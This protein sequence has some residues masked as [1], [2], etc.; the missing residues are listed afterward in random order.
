MGSTMG[1][2]MTHFALTIWLWEQTHQVLPIALLAFWT[3]VP[4]LIAA[5]FSGAI[6]DRWPR[7]YL[8]LLGDT[9]AGVSTVTILLLYLT[10][11]LQ[12]WHFYAA[13]I[14]TGIFAQLQTLAYT[15]SI[16][17]LLPETF[18]NRASGMASVLHYG[19]II[20]APAI[21][22]I[23]YPLIRF[24][25]ILAIDLGTFLF[26]FSTV[27]FIRIPPLQAKKKSE[28]TKVKKT[29]NQDIREGM[30]Y[31]LMRP[32]LLFLLFISALFQFVHDIG[33]SVYSPLILARSQ[34]NP[35]VLGLASAAAGL[36][37]ILGSIGVSIKPLPG[38]KT[39]ALF[40]GMV[41]AG[42]CKTVFGLGQNL[43]VWFPAQF[44]S[45]VNFPVMASAKQAILW[46]DVKPELQGRVFA[47]ASLLT[48]IA[49]P[50]AK[51]LAGWLAD[52]FFEPAMRENGALSGSLGGLFG[53]NSGAGMAVLYTLSSLGLIAVGSIAF[54]TRRE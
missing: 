20:I 51:P 37:G 36:G 30:A 5:P 46:T 38:R 24:S 50:L 27:A 23:L 53:T 10:E 1:S 42:L 54:L 39:H 40:G 43:W 3:E 44:A 41:G 47:V 52:R 4:R 26:A 17:T 7:K 12:I 16:S 18:Y 13:G 29:L 21:A 28:E 32:N 49:S 15:A 45:S 31:I 35:Q 11:S 14:V 6:A 34:D 33:K 8:I 2:Y 19:S 22:G 25:G 48:G 9:V